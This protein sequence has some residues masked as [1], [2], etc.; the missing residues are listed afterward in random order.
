ME[1]F[2]YG[3]FMDENI[4]QENGV[5]PDNP[6]LGYIAD[7]GLKIWERASLVPSHDDQAWGILMT[8]DAEAVVA[9]YKEASV[10]DYVPT[11]VDVITSN[12]ESWKATCYNLPIDM[13]SG[14]NAVYAHSLYELAKTKGLP[15]DY[16]QE[17]E[18]QKG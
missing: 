2:F 14:T 3:L 6:R 7:Y 15:E 4:L 11:A 9:L 5:L 10:A 1:V 12:G 17:I 18:K 8:V 16:L 13:I